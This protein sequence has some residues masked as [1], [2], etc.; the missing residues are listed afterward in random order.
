MRREMLADCSMLPELEH[1]FKIHSETTNEAM[2]INDENETAKIYCSYYFVLTELVASSY[3]FL[4]NTSDSSDALKAT[5]DET[6]NWY[7][8]V[9]NAPQSSSWS[10]I[11]LVSNIESKMTTDGNSRKANSVNFKASLLY[12]L[13]TIWYP[14]AFF[15]ERKMDFQIKNWEILSWNYIF[16]SIWSFTLSSR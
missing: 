6:E 10:N 7:E 13:M 5:S 9:R 16:Q 2:W 12:L 14:S 11:V 1:F 4:C 8:K 3:S 15:T